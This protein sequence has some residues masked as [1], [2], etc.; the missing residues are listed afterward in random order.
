MTYTYKLARRL[1]ISRDLAMLNVLVL[2]AACAGETTAPEASATSSTPAVPN[3]PVGFRVLPGTVTIET[4]QQIRFRG[5]MRTLSGQVLA[6]PLTWEASGG[7][8]DSTGRFSAAQPGT[9]RIVGRGLGRGR[10]QPQQPDTSVVLV[11]AREPAL[12]GIRVTPRASKVDA[13]ETRSFTA[14]GRLPNG[15]TA[16]I[17]VIWTATGGTID[18][19]GVYQA[20]SAAGTYRVIATDTRGILADTVKVTIN[21]PV[22]SD[23]IPDPTPEPA[24]DPTPEPTPDPTPALAR[25]VLRPASVFLATG[26]THQFAAFGRST[27]G[28]SLAID[29]AFRATGGTI[30]ST[31]LYTAGQS[32]GTYKVIATS[33]ELADTA[34]V[35]LARSSSSGGT[36]GIPYGPYSAWEGTTYKA[37][38]DVFGLR[39]GTYSARDILER[40]EVARSKGKR[41]ILGMTGG[42][43]EQYKTDGV[44]DITKW[45]AKMETYNTAAIKTAVAAAVA[46]GTIVGNNVMDEPHNTAHA[47]SWGPRGTMTKARVDEMC[48]YVKAMF[49]TLPVGV[50]HP[51]DVFEPTKSYRVC[52]FIV[53]QYS[54]RKT[55]G[56]IQR[57]RDEALAMG[58]RDGHAIAFS[59]NI[60]DGGIQAARDGLWSCSA[61]LTGGRGTYDPNCRMTAQ[62]VREWGMALG[63]AGC[64]LTMWRYDVN[65]M[66]KTENQ[67]AFRAVATHLANLPS[68]SCRRT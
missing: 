34:V 28:D 22:T 59:L 24:P 51:H 47:S 10:G 43:H 41:L 52:D 60:L 17:G 57:F 66:A 55:L 44:F 40:I 62:Q 11:V 37:N 25:V 6:P 5:E 35:T 4:N 63:S 16:P 26:S 15:A 42:S 53:S 21:V 12:I 20:G 3:G 67:E 56:D 18:P 30:T 32:A 58:R 65:F 50:V 27:A 38:T 49:P 48:G 54:H 31:G 36:V 39:I 46:D 29:V 61:T 9:Y 1:A 23:T 13:G 2:L 19:A 68:K 33:S 45:R 7:S 64:A 14:L 8:I